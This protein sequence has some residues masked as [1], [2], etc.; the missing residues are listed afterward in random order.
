MAQHPEKV[1]DQES[2]CFQTVLKRMDP[3]LLQGYNKFIHE[4]ILQGIC[5]SNLT[6]SS[7]SRCLFNLNKET[8]DFMVG[9]AV[10][11]YDDRAPSHIKAYG[12]HEGA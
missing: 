5:H 1:D 12:I 8:I 3:L 7:L 9:K 11:F 10:A 6:L 2:E 4:V